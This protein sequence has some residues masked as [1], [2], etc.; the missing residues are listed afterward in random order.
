MRFLADMGIALDVCVALRSAGHDVAH[1]SERG[2]IR[3]S[4]TDI[5]IDAAMEGRIILT[6]DLDFGG[7]LAAS[8][9]TR[10]SIITFRLNDM[11][12]PS[13]TTHLLD[14]LARHKSALLDGAAITITDAGARCRL[15][16]IDSD[17]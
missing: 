2:H 15:L 5:M 13:V 17:E 1:L 8:Q 10:P 3:H 11:S 12:P 4:D 7:L 6:H 9:A 14:V 16:P